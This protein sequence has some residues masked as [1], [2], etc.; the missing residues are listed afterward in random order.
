MPCQPKIFRALDAKGAIGYI[1]IHSLH[2]VNEEIHS[3]LEAVLS[4]P[5][6]NNA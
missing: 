1:P 5:L 4:C 2:H 6:K 3:H